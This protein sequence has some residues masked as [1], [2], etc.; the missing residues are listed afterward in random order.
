MHAVMDGNFCCDTDMRLDT[1]QTG[2]INGLTD[3]SV[4]FNRPRMHRVPVYTDKT[5]ND[6][7]GKR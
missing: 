6:E 3:C 4:R 1:S 7:T 5:K 2:W